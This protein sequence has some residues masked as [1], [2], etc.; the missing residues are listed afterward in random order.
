MLAVFKNSERFPV[1]AQYPNHE[2]VFA[3]TSRVVGSRGQAEVGLGY[4]SPE[5]PTKVI[6][7]LEAPM[8]L[9]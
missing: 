9:S 7:S 1:T 3:R 8:V 6:V 5:D 4:V 2:A